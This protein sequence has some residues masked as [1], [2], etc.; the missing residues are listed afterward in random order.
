MRPRPVV[1][2][3][4]LNLPRPAPARPRTSLALRLAQNQTATVTT[5]CR[6]TISCLSPTTSSSINRKYAS[7]QTQ[8]RRWLRHEFKLL[9]RYLFISVGAVGCVS[10]LYFFYLEETRER[11][12]PT[13]HEWTWGERKLF[14]DAH[15][16]TNPERRVSWS[17]AYHFA[18]NLCLA[19]EDEKRSGGN[20]P[21]LSG[22]EDPNDEIPWEFISHDISGMSE[23]W[24]QGYFDTIMLAAKAAGQCDGWLKERGATKGMVWAPEYVIGPSNP[25]PTPIPP[26]SP[27]AP[28]EEDCEVAFPPAD[29]Y[30]LKILATKGL[31][32]GQKIQALLEYATF[33]ELRRRPED[34]PALYRNAL[35]VATEGMDQTK[36]PFNPKTL[37]LKD[38][39]PA[40]SE[41]ILN[42]ITALAN[43][44]ARTG[45]TASA[46]PIYISLLKARR[47]LPDKKPRTPQPPKPKLPL[48]RRVL[49][50]LGEPPYPP[51]PPDGTQPPWRS[52]EE[53]CHEASLTLYIGEILYTSNSYEDGIAWTREGVD[54]SEEQLRALSHLTK[55]E[56]QTP[57]ARC[58][59]CLKTGLDNW[60]VMVTRL[61]SEERAKKNAK[62][63][64]LSFWSGEKQADG[65]WEAEGLVVLERM[66]RTLDLVEDVK[67]LDKGPTRYFSA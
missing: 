13:P 33:T 43:N 9:V 50:L 35:A 36:L 5:R 67:R 16:W 11:E 27:P 4:W 2:R 28:R 42:A 44:K 20:I 31:N 56:A 41:N 57:K 10:V 30:Y 39:A 52:P 25:R 62:P 63:S 22:V 19:F 24:K 48:W 15:K 12:Y 61:A 32:A 17:N 53:R 58:R 60:S 34:A 14:R 59:E 66:K 21:R 46:L 45:D 26:M 29:R 1:R 64:V 38:K 54:I 8:R 23:E 7:D 6:P 55:R 3:V 49:E 40:P 51:P 18:R 65:R 37:V 47:A